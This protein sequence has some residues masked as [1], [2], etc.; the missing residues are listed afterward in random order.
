[1]RAPCGSMGG[2][3]EP[4]KPQAELG[5]WDAAVAACRSGERLMDDKTRNADTDFVPL[6]D[7]VAVMAALHG[8]LAGFDGRK[9]EVDAV[10]LRV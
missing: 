3:A 8:S 1:M 5:Q 10:L 6:L 9:L 2:H 4:A 7:R